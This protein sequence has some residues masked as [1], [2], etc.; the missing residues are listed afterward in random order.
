[1][2]KILNLT[3]HPVVVLVDDPNGVVVGFTG[4]APRVTEV[5]CRVVALLVPTGTVAR[6]QQVDCKV[7]ELVVGFGGEVVELVMTTYGTP[8]GL[9]ELEEGTYLVVSILTAQAAKAAGRS[10][11]DLLITSDTVRDVVGKIVGCRK[12]AVNL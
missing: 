11:A 9:P 5:R 1:M 7:G 8:E 2:A 6:A 12:F 10:T 3:P 4:V